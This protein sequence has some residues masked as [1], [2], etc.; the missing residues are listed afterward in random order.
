MKD[1]QPLDKRSMIDTKQNILSKAG[2]LFYFQGFNNTGI[3]QITK[4][5][6]I[7][8]PSL[9]YHFDSKITLG[10]AYIEERA[11]LLFAMLIGL[12]ER[13]Q[14]YDGYLSE[15]SSTLILLARKGEF[16]GCPF[17]AF[18]SELNEKERS[19]F[20]ETLQSVESRWLSIQEKTYL[21]YH[22]TAIDSKLVARRILILH[23]GCVMLYRASRNIKY[24]KQFKAELKTLSSEL[25]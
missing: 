18:A 22:P 13:N 4:E 1:Y 10:K 11:R 16:F 7:T 5:C 12:K 21:H 3:D 9:Y 24:L 2:Y 20:E 19:E 25:S 8:K 23:T 17:T 15:W 6:E 14:S